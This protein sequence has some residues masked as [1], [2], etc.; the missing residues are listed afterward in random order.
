MRRKRLVKSLL[1]SALQQAVYMLVGL[2]LPR[3]LIE[4]YGSEVNGLV[5]SVTQFLGYISLLE[6]GLSSVVSSSLYKPLAEHNED[7]ISRIIIAS[8]RFFRRIAKILVIYTIGLTIVYPV[9][10]DNQ[11]SFWYT[12][13]LIM[14]IAISSFGQYYFGLTWTIL[15]NADQ[16]PYVGY[17]IQTF[18]ITVNLVCSIVLIKM[19]MPIQIVK[20]ISSLIFILR[21]LL[22]TLYV[23]KHYRI[24]RS[25]AITENSIKQRKNGIAQHVAFA[26]FKNT[27]V[28]VLT[29][30]STLKM[31]SVYSVY[32]YVVDAVS[33]LAQTLMTSMTAML[34]NLLAKKEEQKLQ[35]LFEVY[36]FVV[37]ISVVIVF[38]VANTLIISFVR[39]YTKGI[40]D[41][42]YIAPCFATILVI[43][44][45]VYIIRMPYNQMVLAA[46]HYKQT[47]MSSWIEA[48]INIVL[49][50]IL[51]I[52]YDLVG[53]AVGTLVAMAYRMLYLVLYL[54]KNIAYIKISFFVRMCISDII[55]IIVIYFESKWM[56]TL[57][58]NYVEWII[59]AMV[60]TCIYMMTTIIINLV[61]N[62]RLVKKA[63]NLFV[64]KI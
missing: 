57:A 55:S 13:S 51:V 7:E 36:S 10:I 30:F 4:Y 61:I 46:G 27:D 60:V 23:K 9:F 11:Y 33:G 32:H 37:H 16:K 15:L 25:V 59:S 58:N 20:L 14:A 2:I 17:L 52:K 62:H 35:D 19:G 39:I 38:S 47:Q 44:Y 40:S 64:N 42:N 31:V 49:S 54:S 18:T 21:P 48:L 12:A 26:V 50:A 28:A 6:L 5:N 43:A 3:I 8:E 1:A 34:G 29:I 63:Y 53:V 22:L 24:N 41:A 56:P 45:A